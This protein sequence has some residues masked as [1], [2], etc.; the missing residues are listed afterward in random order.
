M[1]LNAVLQD[2]PVNYRTIPC[3]KTFKSSTSLEKVEQ[4]V[5]DA[6]MK[7]AI[8]DEQYIIHRVY[9][10][11]VETFNYKLTYIATIYYS[12]VYSPEEWREMS[13]EG[14]V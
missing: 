1:M 3:V 5:N 12:R 6:L 11:S 4:K 2:L 9:P 10:V 13:W 8:A 14:V 7:L